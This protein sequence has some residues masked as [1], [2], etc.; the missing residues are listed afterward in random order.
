V[1]A[2][3]GIERHAH[4]WLMKGWEEAGA[5]I[6]WEDQVIAEDTHRLLAIEAT[7]NTQHRLPRRETPRLGL[8]RPTQQRGDGDVEAELAAE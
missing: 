6:E 3:V 5:G 7:A 8:D 1:P 2:F 4:S